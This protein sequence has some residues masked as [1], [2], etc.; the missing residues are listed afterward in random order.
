MAI[1]RIEHS[2]PDYGRWKKAFDSD[3]VGRQ[4]GGVRGYRVSRPI[5]NPNYVIIDLE[6]GTSGEAEAFRG[7]LRELWR[8]AGGQVMQNPQV[9][10]VETV[11]SK[12]Y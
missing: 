6:F 9:R 3:P 4:G 1:L 7:K 8:G 5:D 11:E 2:V 12:E 10:I